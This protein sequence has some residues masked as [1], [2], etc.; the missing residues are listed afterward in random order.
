VRA[1]AQTV[2][3]AAAG[4][5][6]GKS[7]VRITVTGGLTGA[8]DM[9]ARPLTRAIRAERPGS[10]VLMR[11]DAPIAGSIELGRDDRVGRWFPDGIVEWA[12]P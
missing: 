5:F 1:L 10:S 8:G 7:S 9:L 12:R 6:P 3:A 11:S 4:V 2:C